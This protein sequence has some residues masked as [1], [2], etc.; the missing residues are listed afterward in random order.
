MISTAKHVLYEKKAADFWQSQANKFMSNHVK[1]CYAAK[2]RYSPVATAQSS[3]LKV[4]KKQIS[5]NLHVS[6]QQKTF[7]VKE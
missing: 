5:S 3:F 7:S 1:K 4:W 6:W 2:P